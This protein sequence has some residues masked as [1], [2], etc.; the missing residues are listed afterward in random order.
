MLTHIVRCMFLTDIYSGIVL[1][2]YIFLENLLSLQA[3]RLRL[4]GEPFDS[5]KTSFVTQLF[6]ECLA[7]D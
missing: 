1:S 5:I 2:K 7:P 6:Q 4:R 3:K